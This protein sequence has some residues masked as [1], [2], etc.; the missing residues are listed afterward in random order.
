MS[1]VFDLWAGLCKYFSQQ[2]THDE[3]SR[4]MEG[5]GRTALCTADC[6][7]R[8]LFIPFNPRA[9]QLVELHVCQ[10]RK[11]E[12]H[13]INFCVAFRQRYQGHI[14]GGCKCPSSLCSWCASIYD[15]PIDCE[16]FSRLVQCTSHY[17]LESNLNCL[18]VLQ[19]VQIWF[20]SLRRTIGKHAV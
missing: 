20:Q 13:R 10:H 2:L 17:D 19:T 11:S 7:F 18:Q 3:S 14:S 16:R 6:E 12:G 5:M 15:H 4:D 1:L 9:V 8:M